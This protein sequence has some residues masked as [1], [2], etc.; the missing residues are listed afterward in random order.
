VVKQKKGWVIPTCLMEGCTK[1]VQAR[2]VYK[3]HGAYGMC[4]TGDCTTMAVNKRQLCKKHGANGLCT[5]PGC[6]TN[7]QQ[8]G[9]CSKH[10]GGPMTVCVHP[11]CTTKAQARGFCWKHGGGSQAVC[12]HPGCT[13]NAARRGLCVKHGAKGMCTVSGCAPTHKHVDSARRMVMD[14]RLRVCIWAAPPTQMHAD[15]VAST[16]PTACECIQAAPP[17]HKDEASASNTVAMDCAVHQIA[18]P[19]LALVGLDFAAS[20]ARSRSAQNQ[21]APPK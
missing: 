5:V 3:I 7:A 17:T 15:S 21:A 13:I 16:E 2:G 1:K 11:G 20:T 18:P 14:R 10:G 6:A 12:V 9:L 8:R 4:L 19:T